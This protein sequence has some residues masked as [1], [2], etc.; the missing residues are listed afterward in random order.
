MAMTFGGTA[1]ATG[2]NVTTLTTGS[3]TA[4]P[5]AGS[6]LSVWVRWTKDTSESLSTVTDN[7]SNTYTQR[8]G[9]LLSAGEGLVEF[10]AINI[11]TG[12]AH[13]VTATWS[14]NTTGIKM[15]VVELKGAHTTTPFD[16]VAPASD[17]YLQATPGTGANAVGNTNTV[18]PSQNGSAILGGVAVGDSSDIAV[19]TG[20]TKLVEVG[21]GLIV[22]GLIQTTAAAQAGT[23]T[24]V[25]SSQTT[26]SL[27]IANL[28]AAAAASGAGGLTD[29]RVFGA[30][31]G[32]G[33]VH[34]C[35]S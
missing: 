13:T 16:A 24:C 22:E 28:P 17:I 14:G 25:T 4:T 9:T 18:T 29:N 11:A 33:L 27:T 12:A 34:A 3:I 8:G 23:F 32:K 10:Q 21:N 6:T 5:T 35:N 19:G 15:A 30:L 31:V 26:R 1:S 20:F 2:T 7:Y